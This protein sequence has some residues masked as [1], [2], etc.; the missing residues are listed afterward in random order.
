M[1]FHVD[2]LVLKKGFKTLRDK[3]K[4]KKGKLKI[5]LAEQKSILSKDEAWMDHKGNLV[6]L[7]KVVDKLETAS[8]Y[9]RCVE[10]LD[11]EEKD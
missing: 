11:E 6:D 1:G 10:R 8:D 9:E 4:A 3:V 5:L 2:Q 7:E